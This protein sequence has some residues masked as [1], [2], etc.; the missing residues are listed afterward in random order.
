MARGRCRQ[1]AP[2]VRPQPVLA[3]WPQAPLEK[4]EAMCQVD[5]PRSLANG[6]HLDPLAR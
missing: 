5:F 2:L 4:R 3:E 1:D 6:Q